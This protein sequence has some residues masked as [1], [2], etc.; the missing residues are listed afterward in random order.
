MRTKIYILSMLG[1]LLL[2]MGSCLSD[3]KDN[4][5]DEYKSMLCILNSNEQ[6]L[7]FYNNG[8]SVTY[9]I[10]I[11]KGGNDLNTVASALLKVLNEFDIEYYNGENKTDF[12]PLPEDCYALPEDM[13]VSFGEQDLYLVKT[14][15]FFPEKIAALPTGDFTYVLM[16]ELANGTS[17]IN[18]KNRNVIIKPKV[19]QPVL[20]LSESGFKLPFEIIQDVKEYTYVLPVIL[21]TPLIDDL[22][23]NVTVK[24]ELLDAYNTT[25]DI[26]YGLI[27][28]DGN[29]YTIGTLVFKKGETSAKL[30]VKF[31]ITNLDGNLALPLEI[32]S[33]YTFSGENSII[34]GLQNS[35]PKI[36]LTPDMMTLSGTYF[37]DGNT[38]ADWLDGDLSTQAQVTY[39]PTA[40]AFPHQVDI[41]L[42][43]AI[44]KV[45]VRYATRNTSQHPTKF[46]IYASNDG[47]NWQQIREF[48][49]DVDGLPTTVSTYYDSCPVMSLDTSYEFI[50]FEVHS[51]T[52]PNRYNTWALSEFELYGK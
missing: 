33:K 6:D 45:R 32:T 36:K 38:F 9:N 30:I 34:I 25:S 49:A 37:T 10:T 3:G 16:I 20:S 14:V 15:T 44:S 27:P 48:T 19:Y 12:K 22:T 52:N 43:S 7:T 11:D 46:I 8:E 39:G 35:A 5:L 40:S 50:R 28:A 2:T 21:N 1:S 51:S 31:N 41:H 42:A 13:S 24:K 4:Y 29:N 17:T 18:A 47:V 26:Q 23:C